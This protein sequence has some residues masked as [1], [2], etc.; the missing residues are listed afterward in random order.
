MSTGIAAPLQ[1]LRYNVAL[2]DLHAPLAVQSQMLSVDRSLFMFMPDL[3][4]T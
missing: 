2:Y 1:Q 4:H 3:V